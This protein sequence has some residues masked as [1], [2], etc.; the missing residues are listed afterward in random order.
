GIET[1]RLAVIRERGVLRVLPVTGVAAPK[2]DLGEL[3][4]GKP[5]RGD[6]ATASLDRRLGCAVAGAHR[7]VGRFGRSGR[8]G[9]ASQYERSECNQHRDP[10]RY[11]H[12]FKAFSA[13]GSPRRAA[14]R[15]H[16]AANS[17]FLS[18]PRPSAYITA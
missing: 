11:R 13:S 14:T 17:G 5:P 4:A 1:D 16:S 8:P 3:G 6:Q 2:Q 12:H 15:Y 10:P 7:D 18:T 9:N